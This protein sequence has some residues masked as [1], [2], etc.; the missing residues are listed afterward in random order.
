[1]NLAYKVFCED[2][3]RRNGLAME[4]FSKEFSF[5]MQGV[6]HSEDGT[7]CEKTY[8]NE[9]ASKPAIVW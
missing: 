7:M 3:T 1:L 4:I 8:E 9:C 5:K 2:K 6:W